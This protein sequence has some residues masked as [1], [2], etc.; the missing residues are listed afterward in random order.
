MKDNKQDNFTFGML[1]IICFT[2]IILYI[3]HFHNIYIVQQEFTIGCTVPVSTL[4]YT[5]QMQVR[6][7]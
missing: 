6:E 1:A 4:M 3:D 7:S 5:H 2:I